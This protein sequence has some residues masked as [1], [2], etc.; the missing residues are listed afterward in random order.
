[1]MIFTGD[2]KQSKTRHLEK[3]ANYSHVHAH[4]ICF[5]TYE[6]LKHLS[7]RG[8]SG[9]RTL[10]WLAYYSWRHRF[11]PSQKQDLCIF[12]CCRT[13]QILFISLGFIESKVISSGH[14]L[15]KSYKLLTCACIFDMFSHIRMA[16][17]SLS[18]Q[19]LMEYSIDGQPNIL[20]GS[21]LIPVKSK[22]YV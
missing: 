18:G 21:G 3:A 13:W 1:M 10:R 14:C 4:M 2:S 6:L 19:E 20:V 7:D 15:T 12:H 9:R 17:I 8:R 5:S 11:D 22:I 16:R